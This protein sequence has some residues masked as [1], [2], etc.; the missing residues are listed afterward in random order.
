MTYLSLYV[1]NYSGALL[2]GEWHY[3]EFPLEN[4][5]YVSLTVV[6]DGTNEAL[7]LTNVNTWT[8]S[9]GNRFVRHELVNLTDDTTDYTVTLAK[10][11]P[12]TNE[13]LV[14]Y[15]FFT[16]VMGGYG[17]FPSQDGASV[18]LGLL[19]NPGYLSWTVAPDGTNEAL[20]LKIAATATGPDGSQ[21][22]LYE[23]DNLTDN[24][25]DFT[26]MLTVLASPSAIYLPST[27]DIQNYSGAIAGNQSFP[28]FSFNLGNQPGGYVQPVSVTVVP[29]GTNETLQLTIT[30]TTTGPDGSS[31]ILFDLT[32]LT[33]DET[34][35]ILTLTITG[36]QQL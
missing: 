23:Q 7:Q 18:N 35:Y 3:F 29:D 20:Q 30:A 6:P 8:D 28:S 26:Q 22:I 2:G 15:Y 9:A 14:T 10:P 1:E 11:A 12:D 33:D 4:Q 32:N 25:T 34:D 5:S 17:V 31:Y 16:G 24:L 13:T 19:G 21:Y 36:Q 27:V